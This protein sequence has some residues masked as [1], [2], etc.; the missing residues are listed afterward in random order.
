MTLQ[1]CYESLRQNE[2]PLSATLLA[3]LSG[4]GP[5][6]ME[7]FKDAWA[8]AAPER[9]AKTIDTLINLAEDNVELD[10]SAI[11]RHALDDEEAQVRASAIAGLWECEERS[12]LTRLIRMAQFDGSEEVRAAAAKGLGCFAL[13]A[14]TG[15]LIQRDQRR[16][17]D[18]LLRIIG[19]DEEDWEVRRR[20][21]ESI[22]AM[23]L[24]EV[25]GIIRDAYNHDDDLVKGSALFAM[26]RTC[27]TKW[28]P[29]LLAGVD[30]RI[31]EL[32]YEA[33]VALGELGVQEAVTYIIPLI[34]DADGQVQEAALQSLGKIGGPIA[35]KALEQAMRS[36]DMGVA[37]LAQDSME[38]AQAKD[39]P[40]GEYQSRR[41]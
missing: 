28:L 29:T 36:Q 7:E 37:D 12:L 20:A 23:S 38:S 2:A 5:E 26:G 24:P 21:I 32:R 15:K 1:K 41:N 4:L 22:A 39:D 3:L 18:A 30:N 17:A 11:C 14:E 16:I 27:N 35:R 19:D 34:N 13:L 9:R 33:V 25:E 10:F 8:D 31:S 6:D 40:L